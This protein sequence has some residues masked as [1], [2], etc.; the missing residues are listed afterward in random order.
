[1]VMAQADRYFEALGGEV[2]VI[3]LD[4]YDGKVATNREDAGAYMQGADEERIKAIIG[5]ALDYI[6]PDAQVATVGWCFGGGW[7][8]KAAIQA[9]DRAN[10]CVIYYGMP[11]KTAA[12]L[13]PLSAPVLGIF[14]EKDGW[15]TPEVA[16]AFEDLAGATNKTV[17][18]QQYNAEHAFANPSSER[19]NEEAATAANALVMEF[20]AEQLK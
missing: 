4:A 14:A 2:G 7:S 10:A 13:A 8:L 16:Q 15:I 1:N 6:G 17:T 20:F 19:Y 12:E 11:V 18:I 5:G 9:E 3:A